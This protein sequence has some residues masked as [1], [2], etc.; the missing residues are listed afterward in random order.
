MWK[1]IEQEITRMISQPDKCE[2]KTHNVYRKSKSSNLREKDGPG[3][4]L[5][6]SS[7]R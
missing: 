6:C 1:K 5:L 3:K 2:M 7:P 4:V